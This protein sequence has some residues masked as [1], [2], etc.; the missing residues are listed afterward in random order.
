VRDISHLKSLKNMAVETTERP[1]VK[2][3]WVFLGASIN[4]KTMRELERFR[5]EV[6]RSRVVER[7]LRQ[8]LER[9]TTTT[10][11]ENLT[12]SSKR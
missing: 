11:E 12:S 4:P 8:Y 1:K 3:D 7:A 2:G 10:G 6:P 5:G 9:E